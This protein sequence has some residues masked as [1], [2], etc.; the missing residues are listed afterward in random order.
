[1]RQRV[2]WYANHVTPDWS[3]ALPHQLVI[4]TLTVRC[5]MPEVPV[6]LQTRLAPVMSDSC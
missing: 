2:V 5:A 1:M 4:A 6:H 3:G